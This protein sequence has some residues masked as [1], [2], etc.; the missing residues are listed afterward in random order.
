MFELPILQVSA[1]SRPTLGEGFGEVIATFG[2]ML[3]ILLLSR[4]RREAIPIAV[5]CFISSAYWFTASTSFTNRAVTL[6]RATTDTFAGI[7][8]ASVPLFLAGQFGGA[9]LATLFSRWL[10]RPI[11]RTDKI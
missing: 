3:V 7:A 2:L 6:A 11:K 4:F 10:L 5:A 1:H 8:P 9:L